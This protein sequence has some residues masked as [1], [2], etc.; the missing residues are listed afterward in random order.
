MHR[1][2]FE[3]VQHTPIIHF[4]HDQTGATLRATEVKP[5]LDRFILDHF[6]KLIPGDNNELIKSFKELEKNIDSKGQA[7]YKMQVVAP[8][9]EPQKYLFLSSS[10]DD[11]ARN[12]LRED[13]ARKYGFLST[14]VGNTGLFA[15]EDKILK[16]VAVD[17]SKKEEIYIGIMYSG[18]HKIIV[19]CF[20]KGV[21][22]LVCNALPYFF[23]STNFGLRKTKGFGS[24]TVMDP[25]KT[26]EA[27]H[28]TA[29]FPVIYYMER[30]SD[31][32]VALQKVN[33]EYKKLKATNDRSKIRDYFLIKKPIIY[34][35]RLFINHKIVG[36]K[37]N[38]SIKL[39][40]DDN[41]KTVIDDKKIKFV[42]ALL[43]LAKSHQYPNAGDGK[44]ADVYIEDAGKKDQDVERYSSPILFKITAGGIYLFASP[45]NK[46]ILDREF[47][48]FIGKDYKTSSQ[49]GELS[50]PKEFHIDLFLENSLSQKEW[51]KL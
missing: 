15:N 25:K 39:K 40:S 48:F 27:S 34:W 2:T 49:K 41:E 42:R 9:I 21:L 6:V 33:S 1:K 17:Q 12:Q 45:I 46:N 38:V 29:L 24:F 13:I 19:E 35:E 11:Y 44:K 28:L 23:L 31:W 47:H 10:I 5:R 30:Q 50:T 4:Q 43:G 14:T 3:L 36:K 26:F 20:D 32:V 8:E 22:K 18:Q 7:L 16:K 51:K 37:D